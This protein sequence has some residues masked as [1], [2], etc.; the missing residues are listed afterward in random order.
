MRVL[1]LGSRDGPSWDPWGR[2]AVAAA[3]RSHEVTV[4]D[5]S[6]PV[7]EQIA[8][9][10][11]DVV[12]DPS[13]TATPEMAAAAAGHVRLWQLGS[14]GYDKLDL[15]ALVRHGIPVAN[16]PGGTSARALAEHAL[17]LAMMVLRRYPDLARKV[18]AGELQSSVGR[19]LA[20]RT[21]LIIG[22]GASGRALARAA[23]ALGMRVIGIGRHSDPSLER[24]YGLAWQGGLDRLDEAL[25]EAQV[26]SLHIPLTADTRDILDRA[27]LE[28]MP[29]GAVVVNV[30]RGGL[31]DEPALADLVR[32]GHLFGAG[33]DVVVD[34][35]AGPEHPVRGVPQIVIT[36]HAA[37]ATDRTSRRR[38][39]FGAINISRVGAG[40]PPLSRIDLDPT[41]G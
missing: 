40:L 20:G 19:Q 18:E 3:S 34:E 23:V 29:A 21:L 31:I 6:R 9:P 8:D 35:P 2:N 26:T 30:S 7:V 36:P 12:M 33:L 15:P 11:V 4:V 38:S 16:C 24:R 22:M 39:R 10:D 25:A 41:Q 27:R 13:M 17:L 28:R 5:P 1:Y 37:G 14:V 32:S